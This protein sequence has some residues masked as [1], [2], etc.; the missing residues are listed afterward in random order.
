ML[1]GTQLIVQQHIYI[2]NNEI[3]K[4]RYYHPGT[5]GSPL[6]ILAAKSLTCSLIHSLVLLLNREPFDHRPS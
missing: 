2:I 4:A 5:D 1:A 3:I 6:Y